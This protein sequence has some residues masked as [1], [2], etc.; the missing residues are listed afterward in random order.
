MVVALL[1]LVEALVYKRVIWWTKFAGKLPYF[2]SSSTENAIMRC[3][4]DPIDLRNRK[5]ALELV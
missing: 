3:S 1:L 4:G 5:Y 2:L